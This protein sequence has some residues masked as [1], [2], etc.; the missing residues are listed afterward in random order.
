MTGINRSLERV[1]ITLRDRCRHT[2]HDI[3]IDVFDNSLSRRWLE[4][5][6]AVI[7][8][9]LHLEK[10]YCFLGFAASERDGAYLCARI[11]D[12]IAA[13]NTANLGY[14]IHDE[15]VL[16]ELLPPGPVGDG[17]PGLK[18]N[19]RRLN[20]LHRYF[21]D[22]QGVD[23]AISQY[24]KKADAE[25][26]WHIRQLNLLCHEFETWSLSWRHV[27]KGSPEWSRPSQLMCWLQ[28]PRFDLCV[29]DLEL[30][31]LDSLYRDLGG[32]YVGVNKAVGKH[33]WEVFNDEGRNS[34]IQEL[35]TST[36]RSQTKAAADFDIEWA[37]DTRGHNWMIRQ[38]QEFRIWLE[39]NGLD[40][41]DP[42]L[43]IGHPKI[44][45]IDLETSFGNSEIW[46]IWHTLGSH[47]DVYSISVAGLT[48]IYDYHWNDDN[49]KQLQ[50]EALKGH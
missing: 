33:H 2:R 8:Q 21:E 25:T 46:N 47:L 43:T 35:T 45:Q 23:G 38:V 32:V 19:H 27:H 50:I 40:A 44:A 36:L 48:A 3:H 28:S 1:T 20:S 37:R 5:L 15:Y 18:L 11:N 24:Y 34:R 16:D 6:I 41:D 26:R 14:N 12:S 22:L 29:E 39:H 49:Y 13:I 42:A 7:Q 10:N 30:F 17:L 4:A 9:N 31:G